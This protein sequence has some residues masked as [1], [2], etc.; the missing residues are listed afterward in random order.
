MKRLYLIICQCT[1]GILLLTSL[2]S[3]KKEFLTERPLSDLDANNVLTKPSGFESYIIGLHEAARE[4]VGNGDNTYFAVNFAGTDIGA[5]AGIEY[6]GLQNYITN[7]TPNNTNVASVWNWAYTSM[8]LRANT[9]INYANKP[10]LQDIWED[11]NQKN[12]IIAEAK[13]FRAYT[14]DLLANLYGGVP[15]VDSIYEVPRTDFQRASRQEVL[16]F[17]RAD[18]EFAAQWLPD[19]VPAEKEGRIV[20]AAAQHL[21]TEVYISLGSY[22]QAV[23]SASAVINSGNY[24]LMTERF[25]SK[26]DQPGDVFADLFLDNNQNRSSG[27]LETIYVWQFESLTPGGGASSNGNHTLR[28]WGPFLSKIQDP[29]GVSML[30]TDSLGRGVGRVRGTNYFL[31]DIWK[32]GGNNDMRNSPF[33]M[34]R[35]FYYNNPASSYFKKEVEH[36]TGLDDTMRNIYPYPRKIE[37]SPWNGDKNSGRTGKDIIVYRLAETYLLRAEAYFRMGDLNHA[38]EDINAV[39]NRAHAHLIQAADVSLDYILDERAR[40]L[41]TEEPRRRTLIR[42]GKLVERVRKYNLLETT[43]ATIQDYHEVFPIPQ[44]VIDANFSAKIEQNPGY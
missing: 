38:A 17:A 25:G 30:V 5:D 39:R 28:N 2:F 14:Y 9:I 42:M 44:E 36:K 40:E 41:V 7:L 26:K 33:N 10:D 22:E 31:Y 21:L 3:C 27:N 4:E 24:K 37:G 23:E 34:R 29:N 35:T 6:T 19:L 13:F 18:L 32:D 11:E 20:K 12:A 16:D 1:L 43:R 8:I 15:I